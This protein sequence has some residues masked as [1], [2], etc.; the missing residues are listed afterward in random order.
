[1]WS[2]CGPDWTPLA[3]QFW[4]ARCMFDNPGLGCGGK[5]GNTYR[6]IVTLWP[7]GQNSPEQNR[8]LFSGQKSQRFGKKT[9]T[10]FFVPVMENDHPG[11]FFLSLIPWKKHWEVPKCSGVI[12]NIGR[13]TKGLTNVTE[14]ST[15]RHRSGNSTHN[16]TKPTRVTFLCQ[17]PLKTH[18]RRLFSHQEDIFDGNTYTDTVQYLKDLNKYTCITASWLFFL[19]QPTVYLKLT[20]DNYRGVFG[21]NTRLFL[22][23]N[24]TKRFKSVLRLSDSLAAGWWSSCDRWS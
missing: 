11:F 13:R 4:P 1:M 17:I 20:I 5:P 24:K 3:G 21:P 8:N 19:K 22:W 9:S 15:E 7:A 2:V 10:S 23:G 12:N 18:Q 16:S 14:F 6:H